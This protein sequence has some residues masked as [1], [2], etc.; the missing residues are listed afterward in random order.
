[1]CLY[2]VFKDYTTFPI[3]LTKSIKLILFVLLKHF[4]LILFIFTCI[5]VS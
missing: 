4:P 2:K 3:T 1:M 5:L